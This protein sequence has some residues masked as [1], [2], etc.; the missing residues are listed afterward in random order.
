ML[1]KVPHTYVIVFSIIIIAAILTWIIPPGKYI[2]ETVVVEGKEVST[3]VFYYAD[4]LP[5]GYVP[6]QPGT[7]LAGPVG[8]VQWICP[9]IQYYRVHSDDWRCVLD[10]EPDQS[11]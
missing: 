3:M 11:D 6:R 7:N 5:E 1:K 4:E 10:H 2:E 8:A 9:A